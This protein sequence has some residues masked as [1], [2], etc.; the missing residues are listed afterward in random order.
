MKY[1]TAFCLMCL[2]AYAGAQTTIYFED[3]SVYTTTEGDYLYVSPEIL[4][5][6]DSDENTVVLSW[7][8]PTSTAPVVV[9]EEPVEDPVADLI[10][11]IDTVEYCAT[12]VYDGAPTFDNLDWKDVC[13]ANDDDE[14]VFCED[15]DFSSPTFDNIDWARG[16]SIDPNF[17]PTF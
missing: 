17:I 7:V 13:D 2:S 15:W 3:G 14:F 6:I 12:Y 16:C 5:T 11:P 4:W 9:V 8:D 10:M 1:L